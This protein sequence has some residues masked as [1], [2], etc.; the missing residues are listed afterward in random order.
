MMKRRESNEK[1]EERVAREER[2]IIDEADEWMN[3]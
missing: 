3:K 2:F 1:R